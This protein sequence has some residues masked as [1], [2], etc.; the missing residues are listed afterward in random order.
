MATTR[1]GVARARNNRTGKQQQYR[2]LPAEQLERI[3]SYPPDEI[4]DEEQLR[5]PNAFI[6]PATDERGQSAKISCNVPPGLMRQI[7]IIMGPGCAFPYLTVSDLMRHAL[8]R[9]LEFLVRVEP[10][11]DQHFLSGVKTINRILN[12]ANF[13][14]Q[15]E[16]VRSKTVA[17]INSHLEKGEISDAIRIIGEIRRE[18]AKLA[19]SA[20]TRRWSEWFDREYGQYLRV[21]QPKQRQIGAPSLDED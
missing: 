2:D 12:D 17:Q 7:D 14:Q 11:Y 19:S 20:E 4:L 5:D 9:H 8:M 6:V 10:K 15:L 18:T 3:R 1:R 16:D 13:K 21:R